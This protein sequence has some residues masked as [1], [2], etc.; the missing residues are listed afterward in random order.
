MGEIESIQPDEID[1]QKVIEELKLFFSSLPFITI[2]DFYKKILYK[3]LSNNMYKEY[4]NTY[5]CFDFTDTNLHLSIQALNKKL[6]QLYNE[7]IKFWLEK[8]ELPLTPK[9]RHTIE[10]DDE[11]RQY[12][13]EIIFSTI[14][15]CNLGSF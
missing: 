5:S 10:L 7:E 2:D 8:K 12:F 11:F 14:E 13:D 4:T 15:E 9:N 1:F 6:K 3:S